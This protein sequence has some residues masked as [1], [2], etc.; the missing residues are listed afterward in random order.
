M[1]H[2]FLLLAGLAIAGPILAQPASPTPPTF[3]WA[4]ASGVI[5]Q[6]P[7]GVG[8]AAAHALATVTAS[9]DLWLNL[10]D[11]VATLYSGRGM[12]RQRLERRRPD[13]S[14]AYRRY[15]TGTSHLT[16]LRA[17]PNGRLYLLGYFLNS[18]TL[19]ATHTLTI[20]GS[21]LPHDFIACLDASGAVLYARDLTLNS[22]AAYSAAQTLAPGPAD[23]VYVALTRS[24]GTNNL[25]HRLDAQGNT[26]ATITQTGG[27][28]ISGIELD[29]QGTLFVTGTCVRTTGGSFNGTPV[30]PGVSGN[31]YNQYLACYE[32][33][34][35]LRWVR[36]IG[37]FTCV[38]PQ[39]RT[40][41]AGGVYW[42]TTLYGPATLDG[43]SVP[44]PS[45]GGT[46][47]FLLTR[48]NAAG[49][50][51]WMHDVATTQSAD[52]G[53]GHFFCLDTDAA[54]NAYLAGQT[55]GSIQWAPGVQT[56]AGTSKDLLVQRISPL[57]IVE[58][59]RTAGSSQGGVQAGTLALAPDGSV[60]VTGIGNGVTTLDG[61]QLPA[62]SRSHHFVARL[63]PAAPTATGQAATSQ[64]QL[65]PNPA[66]SRLVLHAPAGAGPVQ[67]VLLDALGRELANTIDAVPGFDLSALPAGLYFVRARSAIGTWSGRVAKN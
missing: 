29:A 61:L 26:L 25:V 46:E 56:A 42:L 10:P 48:L 45:N 62:V 21:N 9:G 44:G 53:M 20:T 67:A 58:W 27:G 63:T 16:Q 30:V 12:G 2:L 37:D 39:V 52:A 66:S 54:G 11:S 24:T 60:V 33:S 1:K 19:D 65:G 23:E 3:T 43:F 6:L 13:G 14:L 28:Y 41:R 49:A 55:K 17:A 8:G 32:P 35:S 64:W 59:A 40:D 57:G 34:G 50:V 4:T 15:L 31:G 38:D 36:F 7:G 22:G 51:Q 18:L 47:D 5:N